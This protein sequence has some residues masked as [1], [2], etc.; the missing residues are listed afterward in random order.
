MRHP[1]IHAEIRSADSDATRA[2]FSELFGWTYSDGAFPGYSFVDSGV[3]GAL[4][5]AIGRCRA[6][7]TRCCSPSE[8]KTSRRLLHTRSNLEDGRSSRLRRFRA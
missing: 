2:F 5:I 3:D 6:A 8:S 1:V 7:T 4:P